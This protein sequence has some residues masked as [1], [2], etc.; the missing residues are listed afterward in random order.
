MRAPLSTSVQRLATPATNSGVV[1]EGRAMVLLHPAADAVQVAARRFCRITSSPK[2]EVGH[3]R[4]AA[5]ERRLEGLQ[6]AP[7]AG[8]RPAPAASG[9]VSG[10]AQ[11]FMI[12]SV[13][14]LEVI[15]ITRVL[16]VDVA[17]LAV[18]QRALVE[19]LV[20]DVLHA[21]MGLFHFVE[22]HDA[23]GPA[24]DGLGQHAAFAVADV[25]RRRAH[26]QRDFVL[27]LELRHVD[28]GH[29]LL[30][31]VEQ[32]GQRDGRLRLADAAGADEQEHADRPARIGQVRP[33]R[34]DPLG[35]GVQGVRLA[36]DPLLPC[37][38]LR[39][40]T[41]WI[42]SVTMRPTGMPVQPETTSAM[43]WESTQTCISGDSPWRVFNW[44]SRAFN[45][46]RR[47][48]AFFGA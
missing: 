45:S 25:A 3:E 6:A 31:A 23:V 13:P 28:D 32:V 29:V 20:E 11:S 12:V 15:R 27:L 34:A 4:H 26:Q 44:L 30:A 10:S 33:R 14:A 18:A 42:S 22:Q 16:E 17:A 2:R 40:S 5:Q 9:R 37:G 35:D 36:D 1:A 8:P 21:G 48:C 7:G 24:A 47:R 46:P 41:V 38:S 39:S 43:A 19:H